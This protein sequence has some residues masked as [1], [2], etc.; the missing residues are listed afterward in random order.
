MGG[1]RFW[2]RRFGVAA[3]ALLLALV[4]SIF[5]CRLAIGWHPAYE[6]YP[7][8]GVDVTD[9]VGVVDWPTVH[10]GG[11]DFAYLRATMGADG[12]D[13][14]FAA[15]WSAVYAAGLRRGA[16]HEFSLCRLA[17]D[18]ANNFMVTVP[19][20]SDALPAAVAIDA[21]PE[22]VTPP[23]RQVLIDELVRFAAMVESH[24]GKPILLRIAPAIEKEYNLSAA[25][26]RTLWATGNFFPPS[27][28]SHPWRMWRASDLRRINGA[29]RAVGWDVVVR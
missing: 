4:T 24:T 6:T 11:A 15:N 7:I 21:S 12:R 1:V 18:Q 16:I 3:P 23:A 13:T 29:D 27:Y 17:A 19:R 20:V 14:L 10:A 9:E 8:Q 26:D 28:Y 25:L 2:Q 22:C 5:A